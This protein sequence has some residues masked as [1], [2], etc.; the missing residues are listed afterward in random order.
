M[1]NYL[2]TFIA[3]NYLSL[4]RLVVIKDTAHSNSEKREYGKFVSLSE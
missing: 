3:Y 1:Y 4:Y 2:E